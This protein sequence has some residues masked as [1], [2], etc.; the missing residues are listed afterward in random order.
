MVDKLSNFLGLWEL[1]W[2]MAPSTV[3]PGVP[4]N[5]M[6]ADQENQVTIIAILLNHKINKG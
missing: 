4:L 3:T 1:P 2:R 5:Y 6:S